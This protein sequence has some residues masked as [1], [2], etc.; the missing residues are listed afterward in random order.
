MFSRKKLKRRA[1]KALESE[2]LQQALE[3]ASSQHFSKFS[4]TREEIPWDKVKEKARTIREKN[5]ERLPGLIHKF[6]EEAEKAGSLTYLASD[7]AD[8]IVG[9]TFV[10]DG[11]MT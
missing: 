10:V 3:R 1:K 11:G 9:A 5:I 8:N 6:R 7:M 2:T 4:R